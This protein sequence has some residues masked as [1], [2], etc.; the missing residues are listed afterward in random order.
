MTV[1]P[2]FISRLRCLTALASTLA[3]GPLH[4]Q[5]PPAPGQPPAIIPISSQTVT[6]GNPL[7]VTVTAQVSG[8][9]P[10][11]YSLG[12]GAPSGANI[13]A[14]TGLFTW[15]PSETKTLPT[16]RRTSPFAATPRPSAK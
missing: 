12:A 8:G 3:I 10:L 13:N 9:V 1:G 14:Q 7:S 11:A 16:R 5:Q 2:R 6:D 4:A 15:T